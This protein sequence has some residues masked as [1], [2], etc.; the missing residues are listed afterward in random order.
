MDLILDVILNLL[1]FVSP[2][3]ILLIPNCAV[4]ALDSV[5]V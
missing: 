3:P 1:G 2:S 5:I 4:H